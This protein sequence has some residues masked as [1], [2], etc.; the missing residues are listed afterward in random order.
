MKIDEGQTLDLHKIAGAAQQV[1]VKGCRV[2]EARCRL[3]M[4]RYKGSCLTFT[5]KLVEPC[6][7]GV[8]LATGSEF[9]A[10]QLEPVGLPAVSAISYRSIVCVGAG[11][12]PG[13][14]GRFKLKG[15]IVWPRKSFVYERDYLRQYM[16]FFKF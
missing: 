4:R 15:A 14:E 7:N 2:R 3:R 5:Q 6:S 8:K 9:L 1:V 16:G 12:I 10:R 13:P 11:N